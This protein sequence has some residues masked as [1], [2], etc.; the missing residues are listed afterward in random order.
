M[1]KPVREAYSSIER[2]RLRQLTSLRGVISQRP[3]I[4][5]I[6]IP[7]T[8]G[9]TVRAH[10]RACIGSNSSGRSV[11]LTDIPFEDAPDESRLDSAMTAQLV[12]GHMGW[13]SVEK[14]DPYN[15]FT[16]T[17][18][19]DPRARLQSLYRHLTTYPRQATNKRLQ[20]LSDACHGLSPAQLAHSRDPVI[21]SHAD[22]Y[23]VRQLAGCVRDYPVRADE[24][25]ALLEKAHKNLDSLDFVGLQENFSQDILIVLDQLNLPKAAKFVALNGSPR[26]DCP[27]EVDPALYEWDQKLFDSFTPRNE[28]VLSARYDWN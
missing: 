18:L 27:I 21:L 25:P 12:H 24:W 22:N 16:F 28:A 8:A 7:K 11:G 23:V 15:A 9:T 13:E 2:W 1:A 20:K 3:R 14:I 17:F 5:F 26:K 19:R 6:H 10:L 4:I